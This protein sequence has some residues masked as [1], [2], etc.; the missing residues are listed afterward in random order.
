MEIKYLAVLF[1][2]L[3]SILIISIILWLSIINLP[4]ITKERKNKHKKD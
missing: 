3:T 1:S 2:I 4:C